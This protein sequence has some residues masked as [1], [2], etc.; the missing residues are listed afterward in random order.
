MKAGYLAS[1]RIV[2]RDTFKRGE[3]R[4]EKRAASTRSSERLAHCYVACPALADAVTAD[5]ANRLLAHPGTPKT[6]LPS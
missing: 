2:R 5:R 4:G 1:R 6:L 3:R